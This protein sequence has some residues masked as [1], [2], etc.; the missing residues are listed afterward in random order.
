MA[1]DGR[2]RISSL[3][4]DLW[5]NKV[6]IKGEHMRK[7]TVMVVA[8]AAL[9]AVTSGAFAAQK[10]VITSTKQ[11]KPSVMQSLKGK[12][13]TPG[14]PGATGGIGPQGSRGPAGSQGPEGSEGAPG[15]KGATGAQ[16]SPGAKGE[17]GAQGATGPKG[18]KGDTGNQ[19]DRGITGS[20]GP[21]GDAG[22]QGDPG[23]NGI[24][25]VS[26]YEVR[27]NAVEVDIGQSFQATELEVRC[28]SSAKRAIGGSWRTSRG[29]EVMV[30]RDTIIDTANGWY[31]SLR[32]RW[33]TGIFQA[34]R[35]DLGVICVNA[36]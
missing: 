7:L 3:A 19:G 31:V 16:G 27:W 20:T 28:S 1:Q 25:G 34:A 29:V 24:N 10:Y 35:L 13:G 36:S 8:I 26:G 23:A 9:L 2:H 15:S 11:I 14:T 12:Q 22:L 18:D 4:S 30:D 32:W 5:V 17:S 6:Y 21:K 33:T